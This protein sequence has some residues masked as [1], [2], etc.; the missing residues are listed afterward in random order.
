VDPKAAGADAE[1][2]EDAA[3]AL[4]SWSYSRFLASLLRPASGIATT[5]RA[6]EQA[7]AKRPQK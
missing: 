2:C 5:K 1:D 6:K 7:E 3:E 4:R